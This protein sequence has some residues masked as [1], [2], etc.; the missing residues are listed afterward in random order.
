[1]CFSSQNNPETY[2][3]H[4][5]G[6]KNGARRLSWKW[7]ESRKFTSPMPDV[8]RV[9]HFVFISISSRNL[10]MFL[11][12]FST[13]KIF[14]DENFFIGQYILNFG[15]KMFYHNG[16]DWKFQIMSLMMQ[17]VYWMFANR[18]KSNVCNMITIVAKFSFMHY[19]E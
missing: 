4:L 11:D 6:I 5:C 10:E 15:R 16:S 18:S 7:S 13:N 9:H 8:G 17:M 2:L 1:M 3:E 14:Q 12:G 19:D